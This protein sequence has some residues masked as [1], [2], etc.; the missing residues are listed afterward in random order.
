MATNGDHPKFVMA[1]IA[2]KVKM[3]FI[4]QQQRNETNKKTAPFG[5]VF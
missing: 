3:V 2:E 1:I 4:H 5:T